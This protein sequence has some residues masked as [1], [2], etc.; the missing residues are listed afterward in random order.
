[1]SRADVV[2]TSEMPSCSSRTVSEMRVDRNPRLACSW[3]P[4]GSCE[5]TQVEA[6]DAQAA[7]TKNDRSIIQISIAAPDSAGLLLDAGGTSLCR[8]VKI[9]TRFRGTVMWDEVRTKGQGGV[10]VSCHWL[11]KQ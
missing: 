9:A 3:D 11:D 10:V 4:P 7:T 1:M 8:E 5:V 6:L 2:C